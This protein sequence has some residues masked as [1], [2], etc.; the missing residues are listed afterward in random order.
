[1]VWRMKASTEG[2]AKESDNS[3]D[4]EQ[5]NGEAIDDRGNE[6][7]MESRTM[8]ISYHHNSVLWKLSYYAM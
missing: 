6:E 7:S 2:G 8:S 3:N 4:G 1:M 5:N